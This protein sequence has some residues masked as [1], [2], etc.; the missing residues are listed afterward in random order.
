[1][2]LV[3]KEDPL[4]HVQLNQQSRESLGQVS[5]ASSCTTSAAAYWAE[6]QG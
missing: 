4:K 5:I 3:P 1:M 2:N 6:V